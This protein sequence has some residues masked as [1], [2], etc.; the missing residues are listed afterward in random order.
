MR[1]VERA[2]ERARERESKKALFVSDPSSYF[3][4][5]S[6]RRLIACV[7]ATLKKCVC[8][9][10]CVSACVFERAQL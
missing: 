9:H 2:S 8:V 4:P 5:W 7:C 3:S 10:I 6:E 1:K